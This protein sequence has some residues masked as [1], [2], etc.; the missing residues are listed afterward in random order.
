MRYPAFLRRAAAPALALAL[1]AQ[2]ALPASAFFWNKKETEPSVAGFSKNAVVGETISFSPEDFLSSS[3]KDPLTS[4]TLDALPDPGAGALTIGGQH[5]ATGAVVEASALAGLR[6]QSLSKPSV[7]ETAFTFTP[8]FA[9]GAPGPQATVSL[10]LLTQA[11]HAPIARNLELS[12]YKNVALTAWFDAVDGEGD[13]LTFQLVSTPARGSVTLAEDGSGQ[14]VYTPYENKTGKDSF[15]YVAVD[16]AGNISSQA[17][18]TIR[19]DKPDTKVSYADMDQN[20][21]H[22]ASIRLAEEGVY[23]GAYVNGQYFF[24]PDQTVTRG[25]FLSMAMAAA[26]LDPLEEVTL[27]GFYDDEAI[28]TWCKGYVSSALKAGVIQGSTGENGQPVFGAG[29][30]V[31]RGEAAVMLNRLLNISDVPVETFA[32]GGSGHW[33]SQAAANLAASGVIRPES[34]AAQTMSGQL[35]RADVAELLCGALDVLDSRNENK[36]F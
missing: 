14:F 5:L 36:W 30:T 9:S 29:E 35:T 28:P 8:V 25:E 17:K 26:G 4:I 34:A 12:T 10:I 24:R 27:T 22:K 3:E 20:P 33:A 23:V 21:A 32:S 7:M 2:L 16:P 18:V 1:L 13:N 31:T 19:I 6:F 15:S 11:N